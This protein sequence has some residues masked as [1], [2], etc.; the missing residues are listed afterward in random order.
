MTI[1]NLWY[2]TS[3]W[4]DFGWG[5][6]LLQSSDSIDDKQW[7]VGNNMSSEWNKLIT[8]P[9]YA[10]YYTPWTWVSKWQWIALYSWKILTIHNRNLYIY[11]TATWVKYTQTNAVAN[12]VDTYSILT[13]K[14][15]S[16]GKMSIV[17]INTNIDT[18]ENVTWY[19][20]DW[21]NF[22]LV[23]EDA[24]SAPKWVW[25]ADRNFKCWVF[26]WGQ[27]FLWGHPSYPSSLYYSKTWWVTASNNIYDFSWYNSNSQNIW[28]GESIVSI[29][30]NHN[31]LFVFKSNSVWRNTWTNDT[32]TSMSFVFK[33]E[34]ATWAINAHCVL[35]V[36]QD[37]IY[38]DWL[39]FRRMSYE[40]NINALNDDSISKEI[41]PIFKSLPSNQSW[42]ATMYYVFPYV[43]L[44]LRDKFSTNNSIAI[45]YNI[46]DKSY[47]T[48]T[49]LEVI[50]WVWWFVNNRRTAYFVTSQTSTIYQ[51]NVWTTF[52]SW[53]I[54]FSQKSKR[55]V[56]WDWV[57]YKRISQVELY[58]R[59]S[60][61]LTAN[62]DIYVNWVVI[63]TRQI[64][65]E[66][67]ILPTTWSTPFWDTLFWGNNE[68][69]VED[70]RDFVVRYEYFN[71]G[72]DFSF[73]VRWNWQ[74]R[75]E[76]HWLNVMWKSIKA[77]D[78]HY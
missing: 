15:F 64:F 52:N 67:S 41:A 36:E 30:T 37:I 13:N 3:R 57:D 42:N 63:D 48:Q 23:N 78:L 59:I 39:N 6:N 38:F 61:W 54:N 26:Y 34:S 60:P 58:W 75:F 47:S 28:D 29:I 16:S 51:D 27:L 35:Q 45:L 11:D 32:W 10:E 43:K 55:F 69:E 50:Q 25:F 53:N 66:E 46:V 74:W 62:I 7:V 40:A 73:W 56:L 49:W 71:D 2:R 44:N 77:Y 17:L 9:W 20:F 12:A 72:R 1:Q 22:T 21:T 76:L 4:N 5:I 18:T 8:I 31:E 33:Q 24:W 70:M 14:S 68:A 65:F 19:E